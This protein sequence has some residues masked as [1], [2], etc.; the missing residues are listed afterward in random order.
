MKSLP[1]FIADMPAVFNRNSLNA[2]NLSDHN[3]VVPN[4]DNS[5]ESDGGSI[6]NLWV[7]RFGYA[8]FDI[9]ST[10]SVLFITTIVLQLVVGGANSSAAAK[11]TQ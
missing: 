6:R 11:D 4:G 7:G 10:C 2:P 1:G 5:M 3:G 8:E 9:F